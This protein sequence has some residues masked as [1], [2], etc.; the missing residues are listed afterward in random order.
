MIEWWGP[1]IGE[2]Y[3]GTEGNGFCAI[4][5]AEWLTHPGSVG[6]N[7]TAVT[8]ICGE[9]GEELPPLAEGQVYFAGGAAFAYHNDA[10]K[11]AA[12]A[13]RHGWTTL[14][15]IGWL[16]EA[17]Y[18][19][20]TDR[21]SF[22][23][24][25]GGVN[26][27]PAEIE[28]LL[29][30]HPDVADVA[31][32]GGPH[33]EMGEEVIAVVQP[34]DPAAAGPALA[35]TLDAFA[36]ANL[37]HVKC[38][39]RIDFRN[40]LPRPR[41]GQALQA[42]P[43]RRVLASRHRASPHSNARLSTTIAAAIA[44][45][46]VCNQRGLANRPIS[47]RSPVKRTS[48]ITANGSCRLST[49]WLSTSSRVAPASPA[50]P[51]TSAAGTIASSR[52]TSR[53]AHTGRRR[54]RK[55]SITIC[56]ASVPVTRRIL[57]RRQQRDREHRAR[58]ADAEH[59]RE[60]AIRV[61]DLRHV[62]AATPVERCGGDDQDSGVDEK[63]ER[64]RDDG[65]DRREAD[66]LALVAAVAGL[67]ERRVKIQIV[68][69]HRRAE[70]ADRQIQPRRVGDRRQARHQPGQHRRP[71]RPRRDQLVGEATGDQQQQRDDEQLQLAE[72][73]PLHR[74]DHENV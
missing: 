66:R 24:I 17:G 19:Y 13:N 27:Y 8:K 45:A 54:S 58:R 3:A 32:I 65:V 55:P 31:V 67:H 14:G 7:L 69:H 12:A 62:V 53:R 47:R 44:Q 57:P 74:E 20:L 23:I 35:A 49:T 5:S 68:R 39:R 36:R 51:T 6:R 70:D 61:A 25:S 9:D 60:Q 41:Y 1:I 52:V 4:S 63:G 73:E 40:E 72:T 10:A 48:G 43:A 56:P 33:E 42:R 26:I 46:T 59:R 21:K 18:L 15:D 16:D 2:Y 71:R 34:R 38:P 30:T 64:Q 29:V 37:S 28:N 50:A 11:T 22:T